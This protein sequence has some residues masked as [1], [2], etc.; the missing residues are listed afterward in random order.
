MEREKHVD[1]YKWLVVRDEM[2]DS[3]WDQERTEE[4]EIFFSR[5][6]TLGA[7]LKAGGKVA[8]ERSN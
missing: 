2:G 1:S 6:Q 4:T 7:Y 3:W 8:V 5:S